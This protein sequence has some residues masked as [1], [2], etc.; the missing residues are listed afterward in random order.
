MDR[1][2]HICNEA[3]AVEVVFKSNLIS[4]DFIVAHDISFITRNVILNSKSDQK[5]QS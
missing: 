3:V 2:L 5:R 1:A 4:E